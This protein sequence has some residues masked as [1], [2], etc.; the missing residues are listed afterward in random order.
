MF[1]YFRNFIFLTQVFGS[2]SFSC[3]IAIAV[4]VAIYVAV[5]FAVVAA[6]WLP[7][8]I[9]QVVSGSVDEFICQNRIK[10]LT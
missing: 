7:H 6:V 9:C 3:A 8:I 1:K 2:A 5:E 4:A 10:R